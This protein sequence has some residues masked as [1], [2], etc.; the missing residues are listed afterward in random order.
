MN[1]INNFQKYITM[2]KYVLALGLLFIVGQTAMA[3]NF[4]KIFDELKQKEGVEFKSMDKKDLQASMKDVTEEWPIPSF[5]N[6]VEKVDAIVSQETDEETQ[7]KIVSGVNELKS[8][9]NHELITFVKTG[10]TKVSIIGKKKKK[11]FSN[12]YIIVSLGEMF[13]IVK[14]DGKFKEADMDNIMG[15]INV[16]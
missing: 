8:R 14:M 5:M 9:K 4:D 6:R 1:T 3:Q 15:S 7:E 10:E 11:D 16:N 12:L 2:K 13:V